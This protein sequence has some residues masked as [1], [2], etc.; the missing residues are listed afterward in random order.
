MYR[1]GV[2]FSS[3]FHSQYRYTLSPYWGPNVVLGTEY[4]GMN[5]TGKETAVKELQFFI[6]EI[7]HKHLNT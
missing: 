7:D 6:R 2:M 4:R 1:S 5:M 3:T